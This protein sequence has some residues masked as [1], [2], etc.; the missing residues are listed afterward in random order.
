MSWIKL[1]ERE[2]DFW[3][4][5]MMLVSLAELEPAFGFYMQKHLTIRNGSKFTHWMHKKALNDFGTE[6]E[7][8]IIQDE[9]F[10]HNVLRMFKQSRVKLLTVSKK[11]NKT[12]QSTLSNKMLLALFNEFCES[13][14]Q[15]YPAF[16]LSVYT[17]KL[18][19]RLSQWLKLTLGGKQAE[20]DRH[21]TILLSRNKKLQKYKLDSLQAPK[22]IRRNVQFLSQAAWI[23]LE[24]RTSFIQVHALTESLFEEIGKRLGLAAI[25][26]KWLTVP[27]IN[28]LMTTKKYPQIKVRQR[29]IVAA[30]VFDHY[31]IITSHG[32]AARK[33]LNWIKTK[34]KDDHDLTGMVAYP[35]KL[36]GVVRIIRGVNDLTQMRTGEILVARMTTPDIL[37]A[38][39]KAAAIITDEGGLTCH[40]AILARELKIPCIVGTKTATQTLRTGERVELDANTGKIRATTN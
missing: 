21:L 1:V 22:H 25:D 30:L 16:H 2:S 11:I 6:L 4:N 3:K 15:F 33:Y 35:G 14:K 26:I 5:Y 19:A 24:A 39:R 34:P 20:H 8:A 13:Y 31:Q 17:H 28:K 10:I 36:T 29:Q 12:D 32:A 23:R 38:V 7:T 27:E 9:Q 40:A 18:E 37:P